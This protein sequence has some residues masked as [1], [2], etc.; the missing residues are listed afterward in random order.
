METDNA[1][2]ARS[3][4]EAV[5]HEVAEQKGVSPEELNPPLFDVIDPDALN[6]VFQGDSGHITFEYQGFIVTV[7]H[8][9]KV[10]LEPPNSE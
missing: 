3:L 4:S 5:L 8:A 9:G 6:T 1:G 7:G 10:N 2:D